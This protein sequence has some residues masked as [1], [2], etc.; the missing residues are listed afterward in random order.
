[1]THNTERREI[2]YVI[3]GRYYIFEMTI[4]FSQ[5]GLSVITKDITKIRRAE[6]RIKI[7]S[8]AVEQSPASVIITD[9]EGNIEYINR[10]CVET[11]GFELN[12]LAGK[13]LLYYAKVDNKENL[14][15]EISKAIKDGKDWHSE[16]LS[17]RK[18]GT[19]FW[20]GVFISGIKDEKN[21]LRHYV[22]VKEDI[23]IRKKFEN[24]LKNAKEK[25]E[26]LNKL[27]SS[28][29]ANMSHELRTPLVGILGFSE[30][31]FEELKQPIH[32]QMTTTILSSGKRLLD[33]LNSI[34]DLSKIEA[35][36][37]D[38]AL[39]PLMLKEELTNTF[40]NFKGYAKNKG[41]EFKL[42]IQNPAA[43][44]LADERI[45][46]QILNNLINNGI[47]F[48]QAGHVI[49]ELSVSEEDGE[50]WSV[51]KVEDT[52]IGIPEKHLE[53]IFEE[54]RQVSEGYNRHYEGTGLGLTLTKRFTDLLNGKIKVESKVGQGSTFSLFL[55]FVDLN[56]NVSDK[57]NNQKSSVEKK[58]IKHL[59]DIILIDNERVD[60]T[61][62]FD[63][64]TTICNIKVIDNFNNVFDA[65]NLK[66]FR[67]VFSIVD[68]EFDFSIINKLC[69]LKKAQYLES[70]SLIAIAI[71]PISS[72]TGKELDKYFNI[73]ITEPFDKQNLLKICSEIFQPI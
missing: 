24:E 43:A 3:N 54:F 37:F 6:E 12:E 31:L 45:L 69:E 35:N 57:T 15:I 71:D 14:F 73:I 64:L 1:M 30:M 40:E 39:T 13:D 56:K 58:E 67:A 29:L 46:V 36:K 23:T 33:T 27:K 32:K 26:E 61:E 53:L 19:N 10:K 25:A 5:S 63:T 62:I 47:K 48:T 68:S 9:R 11:S 52:G 70:L 60:S 72:S 16:I 38:F 34:L 4:Y 41:L 44:A 55:P 28:F 20:E 66:S 17:E 21:I 49:V 22:V 7:L 18:N 65:L 2:N 42:I 51:I 59:H 8:L 50:K